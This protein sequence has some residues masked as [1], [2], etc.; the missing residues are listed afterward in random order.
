MHIYIYTY[1][2]TYIHIVIVIV[3][4]IIIVIVIVIVI[5]IIIVIVI[6]IVVDREIALRAET[7]RLGV[8]KKTRLWDGDPR[9]EIVRVLF[10]KT[11]RSYH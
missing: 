6:V 8:P 10:M 7:L 1:I 5:V 9:F 4:M 3:I 11:Y 2:H